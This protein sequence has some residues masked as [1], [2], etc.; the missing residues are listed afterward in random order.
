MNA[1]PA[2]QKFSFVV[3]HVSFQSL[4]PV[5]SDFIIANKLHNNKFTR[6]L[7][8]TYIAVQHVVDFLSKKDDKSHFV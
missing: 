8:K 3:L 2:L 5:S 1:G 7:H 4:W 6:C